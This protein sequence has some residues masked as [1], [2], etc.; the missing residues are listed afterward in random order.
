MTENAATNP[1]RSSRSP[2]RWAT[3][4]DL[5]AIHTWLIEEDA[6]EVPGNFLCNWSLLERAHHDGELLVYVDGKTCLPVAFQLGMLIRP[7]ILQ[8]RY[9]YRGMGIGRK[10][11]EHCIALAMGQDECLLFIECKPST[12][13][14]FWEQMGFALVENA[15]GKNCAYQVIE[16]S[17]QLPQQGV[18]AAVVIRFFPEE[19]K[20][21]LTTK[22]YSVCSPQAMLAADGGVYLA[23][24][25]QFHKEAFP[26]V[27]DVVIEIEVNG[28]CRFRDKAKCE[29]ACRMGVTSC[30]N[31]YYIDTI[32]ALYL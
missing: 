24:R 13:I 12:S 18:A 1:S 14:P 8:V 25:V 9:D 23:Q 2:I 15:S 10:M 20:W 30:T 11:V 32:Q 26:N 6:Q 19:R 27:R 16:K 21:E 22:P 7:G 28:T 17:L 31:G 29:K 4:A 3:D 5:E